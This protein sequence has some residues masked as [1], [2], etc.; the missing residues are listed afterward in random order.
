VGTSDDESLSSFAIGRYA[1]NGT[2]IV[3][4]RGD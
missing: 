2:T 3:H 1:T 4:P